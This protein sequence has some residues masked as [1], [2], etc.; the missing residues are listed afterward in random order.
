MSLF[1]WLVRHRRIGLHSL[2]SPDFNRLMTGDGA[3]TI[4]NRASCLEI[5][6]FDNRTQ[7]SNI[8]MTDQVISPLRRRMIE[9]GDPEVRA[10]TPHDYV[11]RV[12][13]FAAFLGPAVG[14]VADAGLPA[15]PKRDGLLAADDFLLH[16]RRAFLL[17]YRPRS[18]S[19]LSGGAS[20]NYVISIR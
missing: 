5:E 6:P 1:L 8:P 15:C 7:D 10:E 14:D 9:D 20:K 11:Q 16:G 2:R 13:D 18:A 3:K 19:P 12:T 17:R 4:G